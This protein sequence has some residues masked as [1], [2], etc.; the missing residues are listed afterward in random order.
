MSAFKAYDIRGI[1]GKEIDEDL[2][3]KAGFFLPGLLGA[4]QVIVGRDIRISSPAAHDA[5]V[6]GI[7]DSGCDVWDLG[8]ATTPMVYF[9]TAVLDAA[10]SVQITASHNSKE[11]NGLKISRRGA[12]P[13]GIDTG[14]SDLERM[15]R[16]NTITP[17]EKKGSVKDYSYIRKEYISY[18]RQFV[19]IDGLSIVVDGSSG[20]TNLVNK[21]ILGTDNVRYIN[22]EFDGTFSAHEPNPLDPD[23]C[24]MLSE[25]VL[26]TGADI[27][28]IYDGDGDRVVFTDEKGN[29][30]QPDY[31]TAVIGRYYSRKGITGNCVQ[32]IRTSRST[33]EYLEKIGFSVTTWKVGHAFAKLK[34]RELDAVF[35]G[36]LAGHFYFRDFFWC[37]SGIFASLLVLSVVKELKK[38]GR[39]M[40][41]E[42]GDIVK[43]ANSGE[44]NFRIDDKDGAMKALCD[45]YLPLHP[46]RVMDFDGYRIEFSSWWFNVRKSNTEPYLRVV[47]EATDKELLDLKLNEIKAILMRFK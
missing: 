4:D 17:S 33:T 24:R 7:I 11:Y 19:D 31:I 45:E 37:D 2:C 38:S 32:D 16:E 39:T 20:V 3:Y 35:G 15:C 12:L 1:W 41:Q 47:A 25:A 43:Y 30:I 8:L 36:E 10:A 5:L 42:I 34:I 26:R 46:I 27:G 13:V 44:L 23:N 6:K 22:D 40:S 21:E 28:V 9:A 18:M 29:F 14:L